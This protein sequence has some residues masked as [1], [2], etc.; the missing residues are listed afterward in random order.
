MKLH[1]LTRKDD[2][3]K[4]KQ[5][6]EGLKG[7]IQ[8]FF[9]AENVIEYDDL[10][11]PC[12]TT[13]KDVRT[14]LMKGNPGIGKT[15][16]VKKFVSDWTEGRAHQDIT[17]VLPFSLT[18]LSSVNTKC[19]LMQLLG[20]FYPE[21]KD[22]DALL[23]TKVL[24]VLDDLSKCRLK[25]NFWHT[26]P[27]SDP[28][29]EL[30]LSALLVN[31]LK[32]YL[33]PKAQ[34][35]VTS[36]S[37]GADFIPCTF[38]QRVVEIQGLDDVQ[39]EEYVRRLVRDCSVAAR[40][41]I[42]IKSSHSLYF[43]RPVP[44][45]CQI[46]ATVLEELMTNTCTMELPL[47]LTEIYTHYLLIQIR[48]KAFQEQ[49]EAKRVKTDAEEILKLGNLAWQTLE[50]GCL[51]IFETDLTESKIAPAAAA[52]LAQRWTPFF[53]E[54]ELIQGKA[55]HFAHHSVQAYLAALY[56][57]AN[58]EPSKGNVL[59][60]T[61]GERAKSLLLPVEAK[62]CMLQRAIDKALKTQNG[63]LDFFLIFLIGIS[64]GPSYEYLSSLLPDSCQRG[65]SENIVPY[66][67]KNFKK[68]PS[69]V[70]FC[71]LDELNVSYTDC[72]GN[73]QEEFT[74]SEWSA[75]AKALL[76]SE[77]QQNIS[78]IMEY[79]DPDVAFLRLLPVIK[80]SK[81]LRPFQGEVMSS[82]M[83]LIPALR[84]QSNNIREIDLENCHIPRKHLVWLYEGLK[85]P[86]CRVEVLRTRHHYDGG[87]SD[88]LF[89]ALLSNP[90]HLR[91]LNLS[92]YYDVSD[93]TA[94][95]LAKILVDPGCRLEKLV[96]CNT[97]ISAFSFKTLGTAICSSTCHLV[98]LDLSNCYS[99][100]T[101]GAVLLLTKGLGDPC[102][103][104]RVLSCGDIIGDAC[105][106]LATAL[107]SSHLRVLD[108]S[109]HDLKDSSVEKFSVGLGHPAC[110]LES[111]RMARCK[112]TEVGASTLANALRLNPSYM[113]E[114][115][116]SYNPVEGTGF[117]QLNSLVEDPG[118]RL[119]KLTVEGLGENHCIERLRQDEVSLTLD[120]N[121]AS[122]GVEVSEGGKE[123]WY[124]NYQKQPPLDNPER[125]KSSSLVMCREGLTGRHFCQVEWFGRGATIGMA[126]KDISRKGSFAACNPGYNKKSWAITVSTPYPLSEALHDGVKTRLPDQSAWRVGVYLD[127]PAGTL[128]FYDITYDKADLIHTFYVK[129]T[130]P[131]YMIFSISAGIRL[132]PPNPDPVCCHDHDPWDM[133]LGFKDCKGS[134]G[135]SIML[136]IHADVFRITTLPFKALTETDALR[137]I[138]GCVSREEWGCVKDLNQIAIFFSLASED[139]LDERTNSLRSLLKER[140]KK[141]Y[142]DLHSTDYVPMKL[143]L[144]TRKDDGIKI[145]QMTEGLKGLIQD[146]F[147]AENV[148]E[149]DDLFKP[150]PTTNKD[151][152]TVLMKGNPGIGKT[153][154]VKKFVSDWTE[155][156][157][158]QDI[159]FVL[160]FSLT[161]LSSV[162]TKCS[163]MQLL[164]LFYPE[165]T[166]TD[167]L[168][169]TKVLFVLDDLS[170]CRLKLNFWHT[171]PCSD[172]VKELSLSALLVNLL[173]GYLLPKAQIW[174]TSDSNGADFIPCKFL[175]R[176]V[177]IQGLDDV[178]WEEY[179]R[180][181]VCDCS[182]AARAIIHIKSS[183]S[184]Y[185]MRPVPVFCQIAATVL[186]ELMTNTCTM[187]LP[188][189][190][191]EIY[192]HYLLIQIRGKAFQ[193]QAE[194][195]QVKT[196][197][198][199]ILKLGNL[200][201][202]TLEKGCLTIFET[203]L[204][205]SNIAPAAA[206]E[207]AQRWTTFFTEDELIQGKAY[208][209]AH[210]SVQAYLAALYVAANYEPSKGNVLSYVLEEGAEG[211]LQPEEPPCDM[212][213]RAIDK[214]LKT[215]NGQLDFF[216]IFLIGI[217]AG[218][219]YE[220]LSSLLPDS[221]QRGSSENIVPYI[222]K[223]FKRSPTLIFLCCLDELNVSYTD[224]QGNVQE[225]FT[226]SEWSAKAKALLNSED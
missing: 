152:R 179:V 60:Y 143:H 68:S 218:P 81:V 79:Q 9:K 63:Q 77:D 104:I 176:V 202:Q 124:C 159:T 26:K 18:E 165:L 87:K 76:N 142:H 105:I 166:D 222:F 24:F 94:E 35:W 29:K 15:S 49:A 56:V 163:L 44:V 219:S 171:K 146:F 126:Y 46:A 119:E 216:L 99:Q 174:V 140:L 182:V 101:D 131:L 206:A 149:Y 133:F 2:G 155:G 58:Y 4:I 128:S 162:N 53:T 116:L 148:I 150:C 181:L 106:A 118:I 196:D 157:A 137:F 113:R 168:L 139:S 134:S 121:T 57:A 73:V 183:H 93:K 225:E 36:D 33:L 178:Q 211:L 151:V 11:K 172:P 61:L 184:L 1:L 7:L 224:C 190:L 100:D 215:Q 67:F 153:S 78:D 37:N 207:L 193:E 200:A 130:K 22:T 71:C 82:Y 197:A 198:E 226:P 195:K 221:C 135:R 39:W 138:M 14:V 191:T 212:Y 189:T 8:D 115:D 5:M 209:F 180:R 204:T 136:R 13:N 91:E 62:R 144:L 117:D 23:R 114:L 80:S 30:S 47:T 132:L 208:H 28:V 177:E 199:E 55:Y 12:P 41:I 72:Q 92:I 38:L 129:F 161:E 21:L 102:C 220:Y 20:L 54:D 3:I 32:G 48:G 10:F 42:H 85:S 103:C 59:S 64:A 98:E 147:K 19:S 125:F 201:W 167:A 141:K 97:K 89:S 84:L 25:L 205:E 75:K 203:D 194:A 108:L 86:N 6:T 223:N 173:K 156:R 90:S 43:M 158:H 96:L 188:L 107:S 111:L 34:I 45:F 83:L 40:A 123:A 51:T 186:E 110:K 169:R 120:P 70:L 112:I 109:V 145:K 160:P 185:F 187:E 69:L 88:P 17:F 210:H 213:Q 122:V 52:E 127:W 170:K 164:G 27:C 31:L 74:P 175:Q 154:A 192:T 217:S 66:I 65:S 16:A 95:C 50:K 214:A